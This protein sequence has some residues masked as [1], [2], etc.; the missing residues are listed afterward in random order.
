VA[1]P[2]IYTVGWICA[3]TTEYFAA[4]AFL[5]EQHAGP[6]SIPLQN[7]ND[8]NLGRIGR[9]N[10]VI[11]VLPLGEYGISLA[12]RVAEDMLH[13]FPNVRIGLM[14]GISGGALSP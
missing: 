1:D 9:H 4:Q 5:D 6:E 11:C 2:K 14:V 12:A 8:Y 3:I 10:V 13:S 7:K